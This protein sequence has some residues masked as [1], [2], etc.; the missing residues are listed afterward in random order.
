MGRGSEFQFWN[1]VD[2]SS[3]LPLGLIFLPGTADD[4]LDPFSSNNLGTLPFHKNSLNRKIILPLCLELNIC[5]FVS[6]YLLSSIFCQLVKQIFNSSD[7]AA[8]KRE[9]QR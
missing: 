2:E 7:V 3:L 8:F 4:L 5:P 6:K 1:Q 9:T